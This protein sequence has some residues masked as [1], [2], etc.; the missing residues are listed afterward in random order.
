MFKKY[1]RFNHTRTDLKWLCNCCDYRQQG[2]SISEAGLV[3]PS[4]V[5][6]YTLLEQPARQKHKICRSI[7]SMMQVLKLEMSE[8]W[9]MGHPIWGLVHSLLKFF[10]IFF[11]SL[12]YN[13]LDPQ[14][15]NPFPWDEDSFWNSIASKYRTIWQN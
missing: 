6:T 3:S 13:I 8:H 4:E 9:T 7:L 11:W 5:C 1:S 12:Q 2:R 14:D 15:R 10:L